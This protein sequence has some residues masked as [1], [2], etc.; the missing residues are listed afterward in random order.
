MTKQERAKKLKEILAELL[1]PQPGDGKLFV[2][3]QA[4]SADCLLVEILKDKAPDTQTF[5]RVHIRK[6]NFV[7]EIFEQLTKEA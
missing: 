4:T 3:V 1:M 6:P 5:V 7:K 2:E